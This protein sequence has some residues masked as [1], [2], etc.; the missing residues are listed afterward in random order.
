M[1][2][3]THQVEFEEVEEV[4]RLAR[5]QVGQPLLG[6]VDEVLDLVRQVAGLKLL[7]LPALNLVELER[8]L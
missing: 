5:G 3:N 1:G 2:I 7:P 8:W 4:G 6:S